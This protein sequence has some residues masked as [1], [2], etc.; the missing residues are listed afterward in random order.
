MKQGNDREGTRRDRARREESGRT[1]RGRREERKEEGL[2]PIPG[3]LRFQVLCAQIK[4]SSK[5]LP[6]FSV[7][8]PTS[9]DVAIIQEKQHRINIPTQARK[10]NVASKVTYPQRPLATGTRP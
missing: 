10:A 9:S 3:G 6:V 5:G 7:A 4:L 8:V 2:W 1:E